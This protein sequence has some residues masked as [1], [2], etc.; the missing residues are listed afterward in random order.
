MYSGGSGTIDD[1]YQIANATDLKN[2]ES[3]MGAYFCQTADITLGTF[4]AIGDNG[5]SA[6]THFTGF[7]DGQRYAIKD[8]TITSGSYAS[9]KGL[10]CYVT[11]NID[12][13][14]QNIKMQNVQ[15][16]GLNY[17]GLICGLLNTGMYRCSTDALCTVLG[18]GTTGY[19][20]GLV[21]IFSA[22]A[23]YIS[24]C[25]NM[26][27]VRIGIRKSYVGGIVGQLSLG[28]IDNCY[29]IGTVEGG[30]YVGGIAGQNIGNSAYY[31]TI[32]HCYNTGDISG[33]SYTGGI[34][35]YT[36][37]QTSVNHGLTQRCYALNN[38]IIRRSGTL[39]SFGRI[40]GYTNNTN[41]NYALDTM[42]FTSD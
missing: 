34:S 2:I 35:G 22:S 31:A 25:K 13:A 11:S 5:A 36:Y 32:Q 15:I 6:P 9:Y 12:P 4:V 30:N 27:T 26:A 39:T 16:I 29:N 20:G 17:T 10:F 3:N 7:Y 24:Q 40:C 14:I 1:P 23:S 37:Y 42:E 21:G 19:V 18:N 28:I 8:G 33:V 41:N 38:Y